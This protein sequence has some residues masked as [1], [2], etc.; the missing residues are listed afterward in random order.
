LVWLVWNFNCDLAGCHVVLREN[1]CLS[2]DVHMIVAV[3]IMKC[4][5]QHWLVIEC[6]AQQILLLCSKH[7]TYLLLHPLCS[8]CYSALCSV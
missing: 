5:L 1:G 4:S 8:L 2:G 7:M 6:V 3:V